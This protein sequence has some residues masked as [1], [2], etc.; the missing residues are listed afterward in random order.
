VLKKIAIGVGVVL[1]V[2]I[3][4]IMTRPATFRIERTATILAPANVVFPLVNDF[5]NW[6]RWSPWEKRDPTMQK[7]H[8]GAPAGAGAM[9]SWIGNNDV[10]EGKMTILESK[11]DEMI[12]MKLDFLKPMKATNMTQFSFKPEGDNTQVTWAMSGEN[13]FISK[14][15]SLVMDMDKLVGKDFEEGL[16]NLNTVAQAEAK[17]QR[18]AAAAAAV[19]P[20][21]APTAT[22]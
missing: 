19:I 16:S 4:V 21:P 15:F 13:N 3:A 18:E 2:L 17:K 11:P 5:H 14:A 22:P 10:G 7:M 8:E 12:S 1:L 20:A 6:E 9:Y